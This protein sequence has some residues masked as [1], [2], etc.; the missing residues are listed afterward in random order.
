MSTARAL[1][2]VIAGA[3]AGLFGG[4]AF[5]VAM[6]E[7][8]ILETIA[9]LVRAD[10]ALVGFIVHMIV[11]TI[12]GIGFGVS[13]WLQQPA[14][15]ETVFWGLAY[16]AF[17]WFLGAATLLPSLS[18]DPVAW[19]NAAIRE[20]LPALIGHLIYGAVAALTLIAY[21]VITE[22]NA[23][24]AGVTP[25]VV[26]RG[27]IA[28]LV[29]G[30]LLAATLE[31]QLGQPALS[32][33][34]MEMTGAVSWLLTLALG[35]LAGVGFAVLFAGARQGPGPALIQGFAYGFLL[36]VIGALT[37]IPAIS[38]DGL[39]WS[40]EAI[41][42]NFA[43]LPGYLL[44]V[45][46]GLALLFQLLSGAQRALFADQ[47]SARSQEGL[48]TQGVHAVGYGA[49]SGLVGGLVFTVVMLQIGFLSTVASLA[50]VTNPV[51]GF[52]VHLVIANLI[53]IGYG[54]L[55]VRRSNDYGS[56]LGWGVSYGILW[57]F[58]GPLTLLPTLLGDTPEWTVQAAADAFPALIGH[59]GYGAFLGMS[60][61]RLEKRHNP[62]WITRNQ[63]EAGRA[64][65]AAEQ[66]RTSAPALWTLTALIALII[67]ILLG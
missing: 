34:M 1:P 12:L 66:L 67:P 61:F 9:L 60:F 56:A 40:T 24:F 42:T 22:N 20:L 48:G 4:L 51:A 30:T 33:S 37:L 32:S 3:W 58:L 27:A 50:G 26:I 35:A 6:I 47:A 7:V 36:W 2:G 57:W 63:A 55:F 8:G 14:P 62:W 13:A 18:G 21:R 11:A 16:G 28:G 25:G 43:T 44:F 65:R 53:G 29:G 31:S 64:E 45:G 19:D 49:V 46:A 17:W 38:G 15:G 41:R 23:P 54:M 5:G 52:F 10:S 59:I 39:Q